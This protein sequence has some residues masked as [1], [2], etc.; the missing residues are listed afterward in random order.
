MRPGYSEVTAYAVT[1]R[2]CRGFFR[3]DVAL[4]AAADK[5]GRH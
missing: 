2:S 4:R 1:A 5:S 3:P